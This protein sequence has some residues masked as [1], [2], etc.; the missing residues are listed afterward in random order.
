MGYRR[1]NV[2]A[3]PHFWI[4]CLLVCLVLFR[5]G[6]LASAVARNWINPAVAA[7]YLAAPLWP[8]P[9][10]G[11]APNLA[12]SRVAAASSAALAAQARSLW[13][14]GQCAAALEAWR[15]AALDGPAQQSLAGYD[16]GRALYAQAGAAPLGPAAQAIGDS[17]AAF[18]LAAIAER[19]PQAGRPYAERDAYDLIFNLDPALEAAPGQP[20]PVSTA[21]STW[22]LVAAAAPPTD[23]LHWEALGE[24]ARL[25]QQNVEAR[26][27]LERALALAG[28]SDRYDLLLR[29]G[30]VLSALLDPPAA[31]DAYTQAIALSPRAS[32]EPYV[33]AG[34]LAASA[35]DEATALA[36]FDRGRTAL[37][38]DPWPDI[39]AGLTAQTFHQPALAEARFRAALQIGRGHF[40]AQYFY[41]RFL[42]DQGRAAAALAVL[43]PLR[44]SHD[45]D[46]L[47]ALAQA[48]QALGRP[49]EAPC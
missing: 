17:G 11:A 42:L 37:P 28:N 39:A 13:L 44:A 16:Y 20:P 35:G 33:A 43:T 49:P 41:G 30:R 25:Q 24:A 47:A 34:R 15:M 6:P 5:A 2:L 21:I 7:S 19:L 45:C 27:D 1:H 40:G 26:Q 3:I 48:S 22:Q 32:V 38:A 14:A 18:Y 23:F 31:L 9:A 46:V 36:W 12:P 4:L 29:L 8:G 10:C